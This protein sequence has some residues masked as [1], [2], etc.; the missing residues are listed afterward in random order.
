MLTADINNDGKIDLL[1]VGNDYA[2]E[3]LT[4]RYDASAGNYFSG[5]GKG[6]FKLL[7]IAETSFKVKGDAKAFTELWLNENKDLYLISQNQDSLK[8][9]KQNNVSAVSVRVK[10]DDVYAEITWLNGTKSR[11]EFYYGSSYLSQSSRILRLPAGA[12]SIIVINALG[13]KRA[14]NLN[15]KQCGRN[16]KE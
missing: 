4:G 10:P 9:F 6:G 2:A 3:S 8:V 14:I 12:K 7:S 15:V 11:Q 16:R 13:K 1:T 5:D